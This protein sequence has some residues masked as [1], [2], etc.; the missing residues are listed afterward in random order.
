MT[1]PTPAQIEAYR[2]VYINDCSHRE[3]AMLMTCCRSNVT[4][5]LLRL[6]K[7]NPHLFLKNGKTRTI[8]YHNGLDTYIVDKF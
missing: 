4:R 6:K 2:L 7:T 1:R 8:R 3:A 5:L